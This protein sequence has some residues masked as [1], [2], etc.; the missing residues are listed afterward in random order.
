MLLFNVLIP[1]LYIDVFCTELPLYYELSDE[2]LTAAGLPW[3][4]VKNADA[5]S[6]TLDPLHLW[7]GRAGDSRASYQMLSI[8]SGTEQICL[9]HIPTSCQVL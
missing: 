7:V 4:I 1:A 6:P 8:F 9:S 3:A 5:W 2:E